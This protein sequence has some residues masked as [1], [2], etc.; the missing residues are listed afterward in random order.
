MTTTTFNI[1]SNKIHLNGLNLTYVSNSA[2]PGR[3]IL[4]VVVGQAALSKLRRG[5][6]MVLFSVGW[7][8]GG[9]GI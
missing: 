6:A 5:S 4:D 1:Y 9:G 2:D 3:V 8:G 7:G